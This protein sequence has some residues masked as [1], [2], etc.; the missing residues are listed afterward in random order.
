MNRLSPQITVAAL[1]AAALAGS[2]CG[3]S[4]KPVSAIRY[5]NQPIVWVVNDRKPIDEP[6]ERPFYQALY[7]FDGH[8]HKR[9]D[10]AMQQRPERRAAN[11]NALGEVP[12]STWFENRIGVRDLSPEDIAVG[13]NV[14][15]SPEPHTPWIVKSSKVGGVAIGFIIEDQRGVKYVLKFDNQG[16]PEVETGADVIIQRLLWACGYFV[17]EDYVVYFTR[18]QLVLADDAVIKDRMGNEKP[19]TREFLEEQLGKVE[20]ETDGRIRALA[21][22]YLPGKPIGGPP[23]D[24]VR[25]DDP[26]DTIPHQLR[27]ELRGQRAI[28]AW[29][30]QTDAKEDN[31]LDIYVED[32]ADPSIK[33]VM[34]YFLDFGKGLGAMAF[35]NRRRF[36]GHAHEYDAGDFFKSLLSFGLWQ[37]PWE[38]RKPPGIRG[39]GLLTTDDYD[40]GTWHPYTPSHFPFLDADRFDMFWGAKILI[41][42]TPAQLR[43]AIAQARF[44]DPRANDYVLRALIARQ[45]KTARY[46]FRKVNPLDQFEV[47]ERDGRWDLCFTDLTLAYDLENL[48]TDTT[49]YTAR[50]YDYDG[51][52]TGFVTRVEGTTSGNTC[53]TGIQPPS[54]QSGY[55]IVDIQTHRRALDVPSVEVHVARNPKGNEPRVIGIR[56]R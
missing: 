40:P 43:A 56:R 24:G 14:T 35:I 42:F 13:P 26:N 12:D 38:D 41:R 34:H 49:R 37:R 31:S 22:Q 21:S 20:L 25:E 28:Y 44:S 51:K 6:D 33:Y 32:P 27:R 50:A 5:H 46:W 11:V 29:L 7:H 55:T 3:G 36:V 23:R 18:D 2:A 47:S 17:P 45:R 52:A 9:V 8:W 54:A 48:P 30:D 15:G 10:R 53:I 1:L 4:Q 39:V 19:L 16:V